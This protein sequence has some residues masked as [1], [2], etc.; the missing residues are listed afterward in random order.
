LC[1]PDEKEEQMNNDLDTRICEGAARGLEARICGVP[2][3]TS[4]GVVKACAV[5]QARHVRL[6]RVWRRLAVVSAPLAACAALVLMTLSNPAQLETPTEEGY[7]LKPL[8]AL[9]ALTT[10]VEDYDASAATNSNVVMK[11]VVYESDFDSFVQ[12]IVEMQDSA[13]FLNYTIAG[14]D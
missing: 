14:N 3:A 13:C 4:L 7:N 9:V 10:V 12:S 1:L 11:D 8:V 5:K 6:W 2:S